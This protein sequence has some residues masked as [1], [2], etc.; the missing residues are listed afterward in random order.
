VLASKPSRFLSTSGPRTPAALTTSSEGMKSPPATKD[1]VGPH[2][3]YPGTGPNLDA[4]LAKQTR[5]DGQ[6]RRQCR[7][8]PVGGLDQCDLDIFVGIN[9][10][11]SAG[12][13][14]AQSAV[15][16]SS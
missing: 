3:G 2:L 9:S 10:V 4:E 1:S 6:S 5:R 11:E 12:D 13:D 16:L 8:D 15:Q 14:D 7:H